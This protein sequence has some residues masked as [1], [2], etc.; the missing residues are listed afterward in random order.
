MKK[1]GGARL[2]INISFR[3]ENKGDGRGGGVT[4]ASVLNSAGAQNPSSGGGPLV[5][6][7]QRVLGATAAIGSSS[8]AVAAS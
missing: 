1:G 5:Q 6:T 7:S 2:L 3:S 8:A 4:P